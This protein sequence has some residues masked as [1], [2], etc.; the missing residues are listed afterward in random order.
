[1]MMMC[2][3]R[4]KWTLKHTIIW[5]KNNHVLGRADYNY[6]HEPVLFGWKKK[7]THEFF[8]R[9]TFTTS[10]WAIDKPL[11]NDLHPTMKP[12]ELVEET[13]KNSCVENGTCFDP[14]LG[15]GTTLIA[16][17]RQKRRCFAMEIEP[18]YVDVS[19]KRWENYTGKK[20]EKG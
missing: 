5:V 14:F 16:C 19:V 8:G 11:K 7:G 12:V 4:S 17:E 1:M 6:R 3:D 13:L 15:S 20:A 18:I 2:I 10:V 9:G